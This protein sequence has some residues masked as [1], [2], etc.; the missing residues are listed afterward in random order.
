MIPN[1]DFITTFLN[2][3]DSDLEYS[4][5]STEN[6]KTYYNAQLKRKLFSCPYCRCETIGYGHRMKTI[7]HPVLR[8][9]NGY[10]RY[11]AN[12]YL[13]KGCGNLK[14]NKRIGR[15]R[16]PT[17]KSS[18]IKGHSP[19][20][21]HAKKVLF[22]HSHQPDSLEMDFTNQPDNLYYLY[23]KLFD[24]ISTIILFK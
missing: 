1:T 23:V 14:T 19:H 24:C 10:I 6:G 16:G 9:T 17:I 2:I 7:Y 15:N 12:R 22:V 21:F 3:R 5:V 20:E 13:C 18:N 11:N 8:D 4:F